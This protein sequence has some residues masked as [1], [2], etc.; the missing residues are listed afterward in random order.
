MPSKVL[1][2]LINVRQLFWATYELR[3]K[4]ALL[5]GWQ[6]SGIYSFRTG[7][8]VNPV[9]SFD[10]SGTGMF[11]DRPDALGTVQVQK[12]ST[13]LFA[14][15]SFRVPIR[16]TLGNAKRHLLTGPSFNDLDFSVH[17]RFYFVKERRWVEVRLES[18]DLLNHPNFESANSTLDEPAFGYVSATSRQSG[19]RTLQIGLRLSY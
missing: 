10:N 18:F 19:H 6:V 4:K 15:S 8:P 9:I 3:S 12:E 16:G 13:Q 5:N 1:R 14:S 11:V 17:K 2:V 7:N